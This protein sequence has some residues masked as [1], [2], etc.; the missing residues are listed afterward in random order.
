MGAVYKARQKHLDRIVA[1]KILPPDIGQDPAFAERFA[2]EAKALARLNHP[3]IV[4][5]YEFGRTSDGLYYFLMEFVDGVNL[6]QLMDASRVEPR[7]AL[8]IVPQVCDALQYAHDQG[9]VH[10]DIKPENILLDRRGRVKVADFGLAKITGQDEQSG[11]GAGGGV[12][13]PLTEMGKVVGTPQYMAPE[14]AAS[15]GI[16]DHRADIYALGVVFYQMLTGELPNSPA[17][18]PSHVVQIDVRLDEVVLRAIERDPDRRYAQASVMKT[19]VEAISRSPAAA[20]AA[21]FEPI[22]T[23]AGAIRE[24]PP[25][26]PTQRNEPRISKAAIVGALWAPLFFFTLLLFEEGVTETLP[27]GTVPQEGPWWGKVI[28]IVLLLIA[29]PAP[30]GT[31]ALGALAV[32]N[33]RRSAGRLRGLGLAVF[34]V[35][36]FPLLALDGAIAWLFAAMYR[37]V[38]DLYVNKGNGNNPMVHPPLGTTLANLLSD[39]PEI[40]VVAAIVSCCVLD[41]LVA[42]WAWRLVTRSNEGRRPPFPATPP[43]NAPL[44]HYPSSPG[45]KAVKQ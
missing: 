30:I 26:G 25:D 10:R 23:S 11:G 3:N 43:F 21:H 2:R 17:E 34:D 37:L 14:Q 29:A 4:T 38:T 45:T 7:E 12:S 36:L 15:P 8:A 20:G 28:G 41:V 9:V 33:I 35:L 27:P 5:L 22:T 18:A 13:G 16:V 31:T 32:S 39:H 1:L 19:Q 40:A 42:R 6:R 44:T 24:L